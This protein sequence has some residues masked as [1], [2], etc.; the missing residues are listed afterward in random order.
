MG[1]SEGQAVK[2][3]VLREGPQGH[4]P[5]NNVVL[6][7]GELLEQSL[8]GGLGRAV[9]GFLLHRVGTFPQGVPLAVLSWQAGHFL[10]SITTAAPH[11]PGVNPI[12][13]LD[14]FPDEGINSEIGG[15]WHPSNTSGSR[16]PNP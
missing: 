1:R 11:K 14:L 16:A 4:G 12:M 8:A 5:G 15:P 2:D 7:K 3:W 13:V 6:P 10:C 9:L